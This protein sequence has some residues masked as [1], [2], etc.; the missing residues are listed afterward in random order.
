[1]TLVDKIID[2]ESGDLEFTQTLELFSELIK[3][4]MAWTL[5]GHYG[6]TASVLIDSGYISRAGEILKTEWND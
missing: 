3:N 2:Y 1:M 5:Q 6:R 4:G